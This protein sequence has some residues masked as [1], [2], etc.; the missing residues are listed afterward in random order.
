MPPTSA[1]LALGP[2]RG[3]TIYPRAAATPWLRCFAPLFWLCL[4]AATALSLLWFARTGAE[5]E[6]LR[7]TPLYLMRAVTVQGGQATFAGQPGSS[8]D[9]GDFVV[10]VNPE[11]NRLDEHPGGKGDQRP[12]VFLGMDLLIVYF[13]E[14]VKASAQPWANFEALFGPLVLDGP[15]LIQWLGERRGTVAAVRWFVFG[16]LALAWALLLLGVEVFIYRAIFG[17]GVY[18]PSARALWRVGVVAAI[19]GALAAYGAAA[20]GQ[21]T[22]RLMG[23]HGFFAGM[24]FFAAATRVRLGDEQP[25]RPPGAGGP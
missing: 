6:A 18:V 23:I 5:I 4:I 7:D 20:L 21:P 9:A 1:E 10:V 3:L 11:R 22:L 16:P 12:V 13:P 8:F 17:R 15:E 25:A 19:P 24:L 2:L 14:K